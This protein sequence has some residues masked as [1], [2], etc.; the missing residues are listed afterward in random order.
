ML[1]FPGFSLVDTMVPTGCRTIP[2]ASRPILGWIFVGC[3]LF[4]GPLGALEAYAGCGAHSDPSATRWASGLDGWASGL[5]T[6]QPSGSQVGLPMYREYVGGKWSYSHVAPQP[7]CDG[8]GC[9][10]K[11]SCRP[12]GI[13]IVPTETLVVTYFSE[14]GGASFLT[15]PDHGWGNIPASDFAF[16]GRLAPPEPPPKV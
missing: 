15:V 4:S 9:R 1:L 5:D 13:A 12:V 11:P 8:P 7:P 6:W 2:N 16:R 3:F 10:A 14:I